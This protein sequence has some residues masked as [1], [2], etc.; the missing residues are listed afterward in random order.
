MTIQLCEMLEVDGTQYRMVRS[1]LYLWR[2][3]CRPNLKFK[4]MG[5]W[6]WRGYVGT[7][8]IDEGR[9]YLMSIVA[10]YEDGTG[11]T[12]ASLFPGF[13]NA[14]FA[15]WF[16]G[17]IEASAVASDKEEDEK[18]YIWQ[19]FKGKATSSVPVIKTNPIE[20]D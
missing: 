10:R 1:P 7:W 5:S 3:T 8:A 18:A 12:L 9:L 4:S 15:H 19:I 16:T 11:V 2:E 20:E 13:E 14:V 17:L 6:C